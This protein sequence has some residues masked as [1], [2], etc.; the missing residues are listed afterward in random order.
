MGSEINHFCAPKN[1]EVNHSWF[2]PA[3]FRQWVMVSVAPVVTSRCLLTC[4]YHRWPYFIF[5]FFYLKK[6]ILRAFCTCMLWMTLRQEYQ[7]CVCVFSTL[8]GIRRALDGENRTHDPL[9]TP[10]T[11]TEMSGGQVP[12]GV[13]DVWTQVCVWRR[14]HPHQHVSRGR[15]TVFEEAKT[16]KHTHTLST[17]SHGRKSY[18]IHL[19]IMFTFK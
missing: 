8:A 13:M 14:A 12:R 1:Q 2:P 19:Y 5:L 16:G 10:R 7:A 6:T 15:T 11:K 18:T 4:W 3:I 9:C 17:T